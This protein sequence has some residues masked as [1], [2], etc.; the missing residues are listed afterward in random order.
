MTTSDITTPL[1]AEEIVA[2]T[3]KHTIFSWSAQAALNPIPMVRGEGIYFWDADGKRYIDMNS[4]LMCVNIGHGDKRVIEAIKRQADELVYAGPGMATAV[5]ARFG[6]LLAQYTPGDLNHFFFTLGG[7]EANENAIRIARAVTGR[8]KIMAR[9]RAYHGATAGGITLTGDPR[10]WANEPG[11][12]GVVR[13]F[14]PYKYRSH[15]YREGDSDADFTRRCLEEVEEIIMYEGPQTIAAMFIETVTGTNGLIVPPD[16][17][18][19]GLR[20][21][22]SRHGILLVCDEVMCGLGRTGA[23]FAADHWNVV[24]DII[25]M[26]KGLTSAY[27]PLGAVAVSDS[28]AAYYDNRVF[29]GG[30]TYNAHPMSLAAAEACV[31]VMIEDDT[32]GH[33]QR[34]GRVLANLHAEMKEKHPSVGDVRS[35][36]LFGV[37]ELVR[38]R[39]TKE[40]MA[41]FNGT[42]PE[43]Q[44]LAAYLRENGMYAFVNW[45][46]LFTNPPLCITEEQLVEA[47]AII[48]RALEITDAA[49]T[50]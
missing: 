24:P 4:Q 21:I 5:R 27:L 36:G 12:P 20:E 33:T 26:A 37:L 38:N 13:F 47:F 18:L 14:D 49:V 23:W 2:L 6:K 11:I 25:T 42:S 50:S 22:C 15:L 1:T 34:M 28:I 30:L 9:Y 32:M 43:M 29:Y 45:N 17:Y 19:Q 40:P 10:R 7:A 31:Q 3:K 46:N 8:Q 48:D 16:G 39:R 44:K 35:I 41:P